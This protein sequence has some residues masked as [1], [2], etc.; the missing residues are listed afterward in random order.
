M[1]DTAAH[2]DYKPL[3][4]LDDDTPGGGYGTSQTFD[5]RDPKVQHQDWY[6]TYLEI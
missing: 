5:D 4:L 3:S 6:A 2:I 1:V